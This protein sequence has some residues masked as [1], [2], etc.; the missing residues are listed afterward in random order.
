[1]STLDQKSLRRREFLQ[2]VGLMGVAATAISLDIAEAQTTGKAPDQQHAHAAQPSA[3]EARR[4]LAIEEIGAQ[5][6]RNR[7]II[8]QCALEFA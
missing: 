7:C 4:I 6:Q 3:V 5:M 1:M 8:K 2:K